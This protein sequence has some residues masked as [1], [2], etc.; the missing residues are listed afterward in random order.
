MGEAIATAIIVLLFNLDVTVLRNHT[1]VC[2]Q[3]TCRFDARSVRHRY[4]VAH[5]TEEQEPD[6]QAAQKADEAF[7]AKLGKVISKKL[8]L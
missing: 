7:I 6:W 3:T 1:Q 4:A 2:L 8:P 5:G